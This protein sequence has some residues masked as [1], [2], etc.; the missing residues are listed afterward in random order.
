[1]LNLELNEGQLLLRE[2]VERFVEREYSFERHRASVAE[3]EG[4]SRS[5]WKEFAELG[6]LGVGLDSEF[7]GA[8]DV[9]LLMEGLGRGLV[10]EPFLPSIVMAAKAI[11]I[12]GGGDEGSE[13]IARAA[14]GDH[15]LSFAFTEPLSRYRIDHVTTRATRSGGSWAL[16]GR[17][18]LVFNGDAADS[19]VVTARTSG[20]TREQGGLS[21]FLVD[22]EGDGV[23]RRAY[24][25]ND[26][27]R[28]ADIDFHD[29]PGRLLGV[30]GEAHTVIAEVVD[31]A[32]AAVCAESLGLMSRLNDLTVDYSKTR[33]QFGQP[34]GRFQVLQHRMVD[35]FVALEESR[36]MTTVY[37]GDV[38]ATDA[39]ERQRAVS[40]MKVQCDK[41]GRLV[42]QEAVQLHG[43][44]AMTQDYE[45]GHHFKRLSVIHRLFGDIDWHLDRF[46]SL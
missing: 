28:A 42:G 38:D 37:M 6:W 1:M 18:S 45:A 7:G 44:I 46:A 39:V 22:G 30:A 21:L 11:A 2:S 4:F 5:L 32:A 14:T 10:V 24:P 15:L 16:N 23:S 19:L 8:R 31:R 13:I 12:A 3:D 33:E 41:A 26:S 40:A 20:G 17:K 34:I 35:M 43:G 9:A 25:T 36:S 29:A 27:R